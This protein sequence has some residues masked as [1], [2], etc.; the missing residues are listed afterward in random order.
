[1]YLRL[2]SAGIFFKVLNTPERIEV[3]ENMGHLDRAERAVS[4]RRRDI[5]SRAGPR[6]AR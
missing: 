5:L 3:L 4:A 1:M 2:K 6:L